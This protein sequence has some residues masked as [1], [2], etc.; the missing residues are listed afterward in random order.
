MQSKKDEH[1]ELEK[2]SEKDLWC[3]DLDDFIA[4][5]EL[6]LKE[7]EEYQRSIRNTNRRASRKIGAGKNHAK[8]GRKATAVDTEYNP[9]PP[10]ANPL[11]GVVRVDQPKQ[12]RKNFIDMFNGNTKAKNGRMGSDGAEDDGVKEEASGLSDDD[13]AELKIIKPTAQEKESSASRGTSE[14]PG[15]LNARGKRAAAAAPKK[16]IVDEDSESD[17]SKLLGDVGAMVKGIGGVDK[18][19]N[20]AANGRLSLFAMNRPGSSNGRPT[21]ND[22]PK[23]KA[24]PSKVFTVDDDEEDDQT[25]YEMLARSSPHKAAPT[26]RDDLDSFLSDDDDDL[27]MAKKAP[28]S[29]PAKAT[30]SRPAAKRA[31][32][33]DDD[34]DEPIVQKVPKKASAPKVVEQ[35]LISSDEEEPKPMTKKAPSKVVAKAAPKPKKT[36][37]PKKAVESKPVTLSPAAKAY[38][39]KQSKLSLAKKDVFSEDEDE[40]VDMDKEDSPVPPPAARGR[41]RPARAAAAAKPKKPIYIDDDSEDEIDVDDN[42]ES[43]MIEDEE[44]EDDFDASD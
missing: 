32:I 27:V 13:F 31:A 20:A 22:L 36:A 42:D 15:P 23:L 34:D 2:K 24:K 25:N 29:V 41:G 44:S 43:A 14:Q 6:Q 16:W 28:K 4:E 1:D 18:T 37:P 33:S 38:A 11:K 40:D 3:Q 39:A 7:E 17:D 8:G 10:K 26:R 5:W 9:K 12:S 19:D 35:G 21:S 30:T